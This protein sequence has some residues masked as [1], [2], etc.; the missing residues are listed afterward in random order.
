MISRKIFL[1]SLPHDLVPPFAPFFLVVVY[2]FELNKNN[3]SR[4]IYETI[5]SASQALFGKL[6]PPHSSSLA[7]QAKKEHC[8]NVFWGVNIIRIFIDFLWLFFQSNF[9]WKLLAQFCFA[10]GGLL[11]WGFMLH[12]T[13]RAVAKR[14]L[15]GFIEYC[16]FIVSIFA[17]AMLPSCIYSIS[18]D[19]IL[20]LFR[21]VISVEHESERTRD[22]R[23]NKKQSLI[24]FIWYWLCVRKP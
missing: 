13:A 19:A 15:L 23:T 11:F 2:T 16:F 21:V 10:L 12:L 20:R 5:F 22:R 17:L 7:P 14:M 3:P 4:K 24:D 9:G 6:S 8:L 18:G 1:H